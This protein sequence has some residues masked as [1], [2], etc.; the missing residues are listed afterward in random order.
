MSQKGFAHILLILLLLGGIVGGVYLVQQKTNLFSK[1]SNT[2]ESVNDLTQKL[3][4]LNT[5][6]GRS[7]QDTSR[8]AQM[9]VVAQNRQDK[10]LDEIQKDPQVFLKNASLANQRDGFPTVIQDFLE[11]EVTI[12]G[13]LTV[14]HADNFTDNKLSLLT[15]YLKS[16]DGSISYH[17][18]PTQEINLVGKLN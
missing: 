13:E 3:E 12:K 9:L 1:A 8:I 14:V 5:Q 4:E 16:E 10:L 17:I 18:F 15:Y 11:S 6:G 7:T 2:Q